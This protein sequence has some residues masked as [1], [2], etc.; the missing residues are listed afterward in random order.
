MA[1]KQWFNPDRTLQY[2]EDALTGQLWKRR[3]D[4]TYGFHGDWE[5]IGF[6]L[7]IRK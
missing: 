2:L 7:N 1:S 3:F 4:K 5:C 6:R